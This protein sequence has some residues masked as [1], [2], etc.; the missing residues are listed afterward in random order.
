MHI[1]TIL[2]I[3]ATI[4]YVRAQPK[5]F[6]KT[7]KF[8]QLPWKT[9]EGEKICNSLTW[10]CPYLKRTVSDVK[11]QYKILESEG[12]V[13]ITDPPTAGQSS[14]PPPESEPKKGGF[15]G[16][17]K[18]AF[19][20]NDTGD[21]NVSTILGFYKEEL[22]STT[23]EILK[24]N[25]LM[26]MKEDSPDS[27]RLGKSLSGYLG[28]Y[29]PNK[30]YT[31]INKYSL[32]IEYFLKDNKKSTLELKISFFKK[33]GEIFKGIIAAVARLH[34]P[35]ETKEVPF[36][37]HNAGSLD[38]GVYAEKEITLDEINS[39][40]II[41]RKTENVGKKFIVPKIGIKNF[42]LTIDPRRT[43]TPDES[44]IINYAQIF[45]YFLNT[46]YQYVSADKFSLTDCFSDSEL[47]K[48]FFINNCPVFMLMALNMLPITERQAL[49]AILKSNSVRANPVEAQKGFY[50]IFDF[51]HNYSETPERY[52]PLDRPFNIDSFSKS[53]VIEHTQNASAEAKNML[54]ENTEINADNSAVGETSNPT[55]NSEQPQSSVEAETNQGKDGQKKGKTL[56][57]V[58]VV[59]ASIMAIGGIVVMVVMR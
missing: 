27:A 23:F 37:I 51:M 40:L 42:N 53:G 45:E 4:V 24:N 38:F 31:I 52:N 8:C 29:K 10:D 17:V 55:N 32:P 46:L 49:V 59:L 56:I 12:L 25:I 41:V 47:D 35:K 1:Q 33:L 30:T 54:Q 28:C 43:Y 44:K 58:G 18:S 13:F 15:M 5:E 20:K 6:D 26:D 19:K 36:F 57:I 7:E 50:H 11:K 9:L 39:G 21:S 16:F 34:T 48:V 3:A 14:S 2:T 22:P